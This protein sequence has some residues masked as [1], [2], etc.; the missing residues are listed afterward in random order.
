MSTTTAAR[1]G[2]IEI[3]RVRADAPEAVRLVRTYFADVAGRYYGRRATEAEL[4]IAIA[5]DPDNALLP[6]HGAF[7]LARQDGLP[8]GCAGLVPLGHG[9]VELK[10]MFV[11][12]SV[13]GRGLGARLLA[14]AEDVAAELGA[15]VIRLDTRHDLVEAQALYRTRGFAEIPAYSEG[16]YA[17]VFFEKRL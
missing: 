9:M 5:E 16:P 8:V 2:R 1:E 3:A 13:R 15:T 14:A 6:P 4:D 12:P 17:E 10:R 11:V 7:L